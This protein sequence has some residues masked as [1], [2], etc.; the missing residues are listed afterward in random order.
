MASSKKHRGL[1]RGLDALIPAAEPA[2]GKPDAEN[3]SDH[4]AG[5][6]DQRKEGLSEGRSLGNSKKIGNTVMAEDTDGQ[7]RIVRITNIEPDRSQPRKNFNQEKLTELAESIKSKGL[8]EPILVQKKGDHYEIIAGER[9]WRA[10]KLA[11]LQEI[12]VMVKTY[13]DLEKVEV[14]LIE[15]IQR[16]DL[17][18]IE[19]ARAYKKLSEEFHLTQEEIAEKVS[20]DRSSVTNAL[21]LLKLAEPVQ[22]MVID[23]KLSM[24]QARALIP[25]ED[26]QT[27]T[28]LAQKIA[29]GNMSV[30]D[31]ERMIRA[32]SKSAE[33]AGKKKD[34]A[35]EAIYHDIENKINS[36][37]GM[38]VSIRQK[39]KKGGS[40]Q[41]DF[42]DQ[43]DLEKLMD[44]LLTQV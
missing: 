16:E 36:A 39:G 22:A 34:P 38:K 2:N 40:L 33:H 7:V 32:L 1:G 9:R 44:R 29:A 27:Q 42:S 37:L 25:V 41:I 15:N 28:E 19:E 26:D 14:S 12:P 20:K 5:Y 31:V 13:D 11:G 10:C 23:G 43:D 8:L 6:E 21:R 4:D 24:G 18:P 3:Q 30:R 35:I 17:N